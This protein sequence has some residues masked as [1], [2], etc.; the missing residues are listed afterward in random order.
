ML[1]PQHNK[2]HAGA[3]MIKP[4]LVMLCDLSRWWFFKIVQSSLL[5]YSPCHLRKKASHVLDRSFSNGS[6]LIDIRELLTMVALINS[7]RPLCEIHPTRRN[8][9]IACGTCVRGITCG[10]CMKAWVNCFK[11]ISS[12]RSMGMF[13]SS[14]FESFISIL[15]HAKCVNSQGT[16]L[17]GI[18]VPKYGPMVIKYFFNHSQNER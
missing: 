3:K 18:N 5:S 10:I 12:A 15:S 9:C 13:S 16:K 8:S 1:S 4:I 7:K 14:R 2:S 17:D 11:F 6:V